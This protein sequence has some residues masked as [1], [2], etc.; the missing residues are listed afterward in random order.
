MKKFN[1]LIALA[2]LAGTAAVLP[3]IADAQDDK[4]AQQTEFERNWYDICY[5]KKPTDVEKCYQLSK[6]LKEK[7]PGTTYIK[8]ADGKITTYEQNK[9]LEKF[10]A[11]LKANYEVPQSAGKLEHLFAAGEAFYKFVPDEP[12][13]VTQLAAAGFNGVLGPIQYKNLDKAKGYIEK[14]LKVFDSATP[15]KDYKPDQW[16]PLR[17]LVQTQGNQY[18]GY[19]LVETNGNQDEA[20]NYLTKATQIKGKDGAGWKDPNNYLLRSGIYSKKYDVLS[21]QYAA[22]PD[23]Q[24]T[25]DAGKELLKQI[26]DLLDTKLIP[27]YVRVLAA[28]STKPD[29]KPLYD[30]TK[31]Q[32]ENFWKYRTD[33]PDKA[34]AFLE[35]F[36]ADPTVAGPAVPAKAEDASA[37]NAPAAPVAGASVKPMAGVGGATPGAKGAAANGNG[38][39]PPK[40]KPRRGRPR[41]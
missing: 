38:K 37:L 16:G 22:L 7:Y 25:G 39:A 17:E 2:L 11:A 1:L 4:A 13:V 9:A 14:A 34:A 27:E 19:Y 10:N 36:K 15:A 31:P 35:A 30:Q 20:L 29:Y 40:A 6:E 24:K 21:K 33:A 18:L 28:A 26:N 3:A 12:Y 41:K 32:F 5:T 23:D 8:N